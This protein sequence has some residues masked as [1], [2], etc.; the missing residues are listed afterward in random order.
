VYTDG[1]KTKENTGSENNIQRSNTKKTIEINS[2]S[3]VYS[4]VLYAI[5]SALDWLLTSSVRR[6]TILTDS[7]S[8]LE[9]FRA[10]MRSRS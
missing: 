8:S 2:Q 9:T 1:S 10:R 7:I 4:W 3:S 5:L 6:N